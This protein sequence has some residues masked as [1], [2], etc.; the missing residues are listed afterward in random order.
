M[1]KLLWSIALPGF[2]QILNGKYIKGLLFIALE[3]LINVQANFNEVII[4][5]FH[6]DIQEAIAKTNYQWLMFY[7]CM[8]LF[9]AW[10]AYRDGGSGKVRYSYLPFVFA[11]YFVTVGLIYSSIF[12]VF[13][14]LLG[15]VWL[16]MLS[17]LVGVV[18]GL[19]IQSLLL[20]R[21]GN[22]N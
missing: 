3:L 7:P 4:L 17:C 1:E 6:G 22:Y 14:I 19:L 2:G 13:G 11:A 10:D 21:K 12:K 9:A 15:P 16:P 20:K 5:S 18:I 8:Y